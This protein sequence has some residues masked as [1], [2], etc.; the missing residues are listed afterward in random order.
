MVGRAFEFDVVRAAGS[1][2]EEE[3]LDAVDEGIAA[4]VIESTGDRD[5]DR[6][7]FSH[8][9]IA[10]AI[11]KRVQPRRLARM[12]GQVAAA[13]EQLRPNAVASIAAHHDAAGN[14]AGAYSWARK[15]A[16]L[17]VAVYAHQEAAMSWQLAERHA[18]DAVAARDC[19]VRRLQALEMSGAYEEAST[20]CDLILADEDPATPLLSVRRAR[21]RLRSLLG[22]PLEQTAR[23]LA[24]LLDEATTHGDGP[25]EVEVLGMQSRVMLRL[26]DPLA[27]HELGRRS[28][29]VAERQA[30]P[31]LLATTLMY[32]GSAL[33]ESDA[34]EARLC[35]ERALTSFEAA[36]DEPG[37]AR[38]WINLG[39][40][41]SRAG[42]HQA[43]ASAYATA[44][45]LGRKIHS[46]DLTGLAA[47]NLGVLHL[48]L[49]EFADADRCLA[50]AMERFALLKNEPHR[51]AALYN[52][53]N[54]AREQAD[55]ARASALYGDAAVVAAGMNQLDVEVGA[56]AGQGLAWLAMGR[57]ADA[58]ACLHSCEV[59]IQGRE[60]FWFQGRELF[61]AL[62]I[63]LLVSRGDVAKA[64]AH[65]ARAVALATTS[66][67]YGAAWLVAD[68][69]DP[70]AQAGEQAGWAHVEHFGEW[71]A[72]SDY[73]P[74]RAR[75]A[76]LRGGA[77]PVG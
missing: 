2:D 30:H 5:G 59:R 9:L 35:Y 42:E 8:V 63:R 20:L 43:A 58:R 41:R 44:V 36:G 7:A 55:H 14:S 1:M 29:T 70:L 21:E 68:V 4:H 51:L 37:Q 15:A 11:R 18:P 49:G 16:E 23:A 56:R 62:T 73:A 24:A 48:K 27:A 66:D 76:A 61:D 6:F 52:Q 47:L 19:Q 25:E 32:L 34:G 77:S 46:P 12:H 60:A 39:I 45:S 38:A 50:E 71:A 22:Q 13:L 33:V 67:A 26:G 31:A 17:A 3:L 54:L 75:Y 74:L 64:T 69:T 72:A 28:V 10:D 40:A 65:F 57:D 53:A